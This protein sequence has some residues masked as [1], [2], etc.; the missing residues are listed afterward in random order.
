MR[1]QHIIGQTRFILK[2]FLFPFFCS[3]V[4]SKLLSSSSHLKARPTSKLLELANGSHPF[5]LPSELRLKIYAYIVPV[6]TPCCELSGLVLSSRQLKCEIYG[7]MRRQ[8]RK[9][10]NTIIERWP[11]AVKPRLLYPGR[12]LSQ[13]EVLVHVAYLPW[14]VMQ[15]NKD[16]LIG[17]LAPTVPRLTIEICKMAERP[18]M[19][20]QRK[21]GLCE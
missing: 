17:K 15:P 13:K 12:M 18:T 5:S 21:D 3:C 19:L 10:R 9:L 20:E 6:D 8:Y 11:F 14:R 4:S 7:E 1:Q 2:R 16:W